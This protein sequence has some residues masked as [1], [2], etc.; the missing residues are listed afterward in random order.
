MKR[1][2]E[3]VRLLLLLLLLHARAIQAVFP[4]VEMSVYRFAVSILEGGRLVT[5]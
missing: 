5:D 4:G 1:R 3:I 2:L